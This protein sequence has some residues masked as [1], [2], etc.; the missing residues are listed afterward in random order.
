MYPGYVVRRTVR[1]PSDDFI[2]RD[3]PEVENDVRAKEAN[4]FDR[5]R[6]GQG[7]IQSQR[8]WRRGCGRQ[9]NGRGDAV[10][11]F[12]PFKRLR[13]TAAVPDAH[14][15]NHHASSAHPARS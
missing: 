12:A 7:G 10:R 11:T 2:A 3:M 14:F 9:L 13:L 4:S 5:L 6:G 15:A 1:Y 8:G